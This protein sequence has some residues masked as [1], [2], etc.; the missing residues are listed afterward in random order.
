MLVNE[1]ICKKNVPSVKASSE[2]KSKTSRVK[3]SS[4]RVQGGQTCRHP[5]GFHTAAA[6]TKHDSAN[7]FFLSYMYVGKLC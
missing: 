3:R 7:C 5:K 2:F 1:D 4:L 6:F